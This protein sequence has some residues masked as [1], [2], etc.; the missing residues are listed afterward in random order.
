[1][2]SND[3]GRKE[4]PLSTLKLS[5]TPYPV[6]GPCFLDIH[7]VAVCAITTRLPTIA[8]IEKYLEEQHALGHEVYLY[9]LY[10]IEYPTDPKIGYSFRH[11]VQA[12]RGPDG[13]Y[14]TEPA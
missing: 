9:K 2:T 4:L 1:M 14:V 3:A 8:A 7:D 6:L 13:K 10:E 12:K 11:L 5:F